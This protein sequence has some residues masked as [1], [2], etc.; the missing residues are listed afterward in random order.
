MIKKF[1][2][3]FLC[4]VVSALVTIIVLAPNE[5][6][7]ERSVTIPAPAADVFGH[8][9]E[10]KNWEQWQPWLAKDPEMKLVYSGPPAGAG[11]Q[12]AWE[13]ESQGSGT[14]KIVNSVENRSIETALSFAGQGDAKAEFLFETEGE[15]TKVT[16]RLTS[17]F[18]GIGKLF[19]MFLEGAVG[20]DFEMGLESLKK[21]ASAEG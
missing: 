11:A 3:G 12:Y 6:I 14:L 18:S 1:L 17:Q 10:L 4:L 13:S 21:V 16:W 19:G 2:L 8:V 7:V 9:N 5:V 20:P 15:K